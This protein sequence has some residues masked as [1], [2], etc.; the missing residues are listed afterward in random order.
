MREVYN[1]DGIRVVEDV[2]S[3][4]QMQTLQSWA[5]HVKYQGVHH[6]RWRPVWRIGEGEPLRG[7]TWSVPTAGCEPEGKRTARSYPVALA[8]L[9]DMLQHLLLSGRPG[10]AWV[11]MTPRI[12]PRGTALGL[13]RDAGD[14]AGSD[15]F[16]T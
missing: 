4:S 1:A 3:E 8:P 11:S 6:E 12:Y 5:E 13:Q 15:L 7:P 14:F 2:V 10:H 16:Y 9:A